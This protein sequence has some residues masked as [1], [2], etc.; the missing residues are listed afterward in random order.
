MRGWYNIHDKDNDRMGF[1]SLDTAVKPK[2]TAA[3]STPTATLPSVTINVPVADTFLI[4]G[5][6]GYLFLGTLSYTIVMA[7]MITLAILFCNY[8]TRVTSKASA[9]EDSEKTV[10]ESAKLI[11]LT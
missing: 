6:N 5:I 11:I 10:D 9:T 4:W 7:V 8:L 1:Y 3:L 2:P